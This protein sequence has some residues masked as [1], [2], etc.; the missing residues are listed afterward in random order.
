MIIPRSKCVLLFIVL[1][2]FSTLNLKAQ[3]RKEY[4]LDKGWAFSK[5]D[6]PQASQASFNDSKWE[7][8]TVPHDWAIKGPFSGENDL[9][10]VAI[11]QNGE[12]EA[13]VKSGRTGGLPFIGTGWYRLKIQVPDFSAG[14]KAT[15]LFD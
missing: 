2:F 7:K 1:T 12:K 4:L 3:V 8:V 15:L 11:V 5:G 9:Q 6:F 10:K 13:S 14:K